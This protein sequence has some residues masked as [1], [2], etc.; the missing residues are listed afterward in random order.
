M[1][2]RCGGMSVIPGVR[3]LSQEN[4]HELEAGLG[5]VENL[6]L[7]KAKKRKKK[8]QPTKQKLC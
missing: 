1:L 8:K 4:L 6:C 2:A 3:R 5:Y 7:K